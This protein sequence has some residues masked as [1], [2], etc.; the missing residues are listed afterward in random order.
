MDSHNIYDNNIHRKSLYLVVSEDQNPDLDIQIWPDT[1]PQH[2][3]KGVGIE[4]A[5]R[6]RF[7]QRHLARDVFIIVMACL[8]GTVFSAAIGTTLNPNPHC[9]IAITKAAAIG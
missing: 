1:D 4:L 7:E 3:V 8:I 6:R 2:C 9:F 5:A